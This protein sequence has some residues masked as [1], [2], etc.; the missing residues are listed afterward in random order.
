[1]LGH[2]VYH[3]HETHPVRGLQS[4]MRAR[5][6]K[7]WH[8]IGSRQGSIR[9]SCLTLAIILGVSFTIPTV[10]VGTTHLIATPTIA[11]GTAPGVFLLS[12]FYY[13]SCV[14]INGGA[15]PTT[16]GATI[17]GISWAWGDSTSGASWFP[18]HHNYTSNGTYHVVAT[19]TDSNGLTGSA[20]LNATIN[21]TTHLVP[22]SVALFT[23]SLNNLTATVNGLVNWDNCGPNPIPTMS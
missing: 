1:M 9:A 15:Y 12:P 6:S 22:P 16:T 18:A 10:G 5:N 11:A 17:S 21:W 13:K 8:S 4:S 23:P 2:Q 3:Q 19:A 7:G 14:S 20:S